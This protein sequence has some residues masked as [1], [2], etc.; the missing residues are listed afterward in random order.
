MM[1]MLPVTAPMP[2]LLLHRQLL[3]PHQEQ[4]LFPR[5]YSAN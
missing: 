1:I 3:L 4:A 2:L 5:Y